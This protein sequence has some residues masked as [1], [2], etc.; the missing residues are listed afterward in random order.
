MNNSGYFIRW[1]FEAYF[2]YIVTIAVLY[3]IIHILIAKSFESYADDKGYNGSKIFWVCFFLM[4][5]GIAMAIAMPDK[6]TREII[7]KLDF[8]QRKKEEKTEEKSLKCRYCGTPLKKNAKYCVK[9]GN[10]VE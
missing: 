3:L 7:Q 8:S 9:C 10:M 2:C 5:L 4:P 1:F 6:K